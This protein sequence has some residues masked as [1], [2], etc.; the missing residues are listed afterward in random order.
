MFQASK[1]RWVQPAAIDWLLALAQGFV[2]PL[3]VLLAYLHT[4]APG[5][6]WANDGADSGDLI[7]AAATL[8]IAH[9]TG[10]PTYLLLARAFQL[11]PLGDI[12]WRTTMLSAVAGVLA[13][14]LAGRAVYDIVGTDDWAAHAGVASA[15][16]LF[17]CSPLL[18]SQSVIA[19]VYSVNAVFVV[20]ALW[21]AL[22]VL[23]RTAPQSAW[24]QRG[25]ALLLGLGMGVHSTTVLMVAMWYIACA[26]ADVRSGRRWLLVERA[27]WCATGLLVYM[28]LPVRAA[29]H[30]PINWGAPR[31]LAGIWWV[32]SGALYRPLMFGVPIDEIGVRSLLM[33]QRLYQ[34]VGLVGGALS[35]LGLLH[36]W[37]SRISVF[38]WF[39]LSAV[40]LYLL[41]AAS[42]R[43]TDAYV[44]LIPGVAIA[45]IW[46]G[47]G[48]VVVLRWFQRWP[49]APTLALFVLLG[50]FAWRA[51]STLPAVDASADRRAIV[52]ATQVL[53]TAPPHALIVTS[54]DLDAFPLWYYHYALKTRPDLVVL[55]DPLLEFAWYRDNLRALYPALV[56]AE[57]PAADASWADTLVR[58]NPGLPLCR[59]DPEGPVALACD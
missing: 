13:A 22:R 2:A 29:A 59:T 14:W 7:T 30:P 20:L 23:V 15:T 25:S 4:L 42:Y 10:Y 32:V 49:A 50:W 3:V 48:L 5:V 57:A 27:L 54:S 11:I 47:C 58:D 45:A 43:T 34:Q 19:E 6:T 1:R 12:A 41:V 17:G 9:P 26:I 39:S 38:S 51:A 24:Q 55:V 36:S 37:R 28:Y 40:L 53:K 52:F 16:L 46:A 56:L 18:W 31:D 21:L 35:I 8:G 33:A 44:Y